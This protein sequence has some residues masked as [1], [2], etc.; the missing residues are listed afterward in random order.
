MTVGVRG[1]HVVGLDYRH[2]RL[3]V[4]AVGGWGWVMDAP[5]DGTREAMNWFLGIVAFGF[6]VLIVMALAGGGG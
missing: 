4:D 2:C 3:R 1:L 5:D 6:I